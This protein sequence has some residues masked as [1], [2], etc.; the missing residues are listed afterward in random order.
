M[1]G[2]RP[3]H[4]IQGQCQEQDITGSKIFVS[5]G[6]VLPVN[7]FHL[8]DYRSVFA[9]SKCVQKYITLFRTASVEREGRDTYSS[10]TNL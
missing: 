6:Q 1:N 2:G 4:Y 10:S 8:L 9:I 5:Q 7:K 3:L